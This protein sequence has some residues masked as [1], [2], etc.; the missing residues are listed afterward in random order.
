MD[1]H[2]VGLEL[3][4]ELSPLRMSAAPIPI[5]TWLLFQ[6]GSVGRLLINDP[7]AVGNLKHGG[8]MCAHDH[9]LMFLVCDPDSCA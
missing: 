4:N 7:L 5:E 6:I 9:I 2:E 8:V 1:W 3:D